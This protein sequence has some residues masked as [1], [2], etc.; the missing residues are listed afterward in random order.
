MNR[1]HLFLAC[2]TVLLL[3]L[4]SLPSRP[5]A[6]EPEA[7]QPLSDRERRE[8]LTEVR[9]GIARTVAD[10]E[11]RL[12][13]ADAAVPTRDLPNAALFKLIADQDGAVAEKLLRRAFDAQDMDPK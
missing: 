5:A 3:T 6:S 1:R 10:L 12:A 9:D 7:A 13:K 2:G 4:V 8:R 11:K